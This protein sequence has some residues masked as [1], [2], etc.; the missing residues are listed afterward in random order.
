MFLI[1]FLQGYNTKPLHQFQWRIH[2]DQ[3]NNLDSC[4]IQQGN[5]TDNATIPDY[6]YY[7]NED[8]VNVNVSEGRAI[9]QQNKDEEGKTNGG[10]RFT[11]SA[12]DITF[13]VLLL[14]IQSG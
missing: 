10:L 14:A 13:I 11:E 4:Q 8:Y 5:I 2:T 12:F 3:C 9:G 7:A 6:E 1:I